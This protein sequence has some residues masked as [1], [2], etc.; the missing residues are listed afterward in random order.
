MQTRR[1]AALTSHEP[2]PISSEGPRGA[3]SPATDLTESLTGAESPAEPVIHVVSNVQGTAASSTDS[4]IHSASPAVQGTAGTAARVSST[5]SAVT[6]NTA[7][8]RPALR[9]QPIPAAPHVQPISTAPHAQPIL[10][11]PYVQPIPAASHA[12]PNPQAPRPQAPRPQ[13]SRPQASRSQASRA[14]RTYRFCIETPDIVE[15]RMHK[16]HTPSHNAQK[17]KKRAAAILF[18][19]N[20]P[21]RP[22]GPAQRLSPPS[23]PTPAGHSSNH[24]TLLTTAGS[25]SEESDAVEIPIQRLRLEDRGEESPSD[26]SHPP[27]FTP[28]ERLQYRKKRSHRNKSGP[29]ADVWTFVEKK[30][31]RIHCI[32]CQYVKFSSCQ[33]LITY[34]WYRKIHMVNSNHSV[35]HW[36]ASTSISN[37]RRHF[38]NHHLMEWVTACDDLKIQISGT[39]AQ[40]KVREFKNLPK[41]SELESSRPSYSKEAFVDAL[42][43]FVVGDDQVCDF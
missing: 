13:T 38:Y 15:Q 3:P 14:Q 36:A 35:A 39:A 1:T 43:E 29:V 20:R 37:I 41:D 32:F 33:L 40:E 8:V 21:S 16:T 42:T 7:L 19:P 30:D 31:S 9:A 25:E 10:A 27:H 12:Q 22:T 11:A 17:N 2:L 26:V 4:V 28:H 23:S 24:P 18:T 5:R 6:R 34:F